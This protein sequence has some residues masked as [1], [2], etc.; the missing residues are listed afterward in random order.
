MGELEQNG[1]LGVGYVPVDIDTSGG[2]AKSLSSVNIRNLS[3]RN[4]HG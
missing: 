1:R 4:F 2:L 3:G